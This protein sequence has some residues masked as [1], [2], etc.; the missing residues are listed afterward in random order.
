MAP[1]LNAPCTGGQECKTSY[2]SCV[3]FDNA[4]ER[5]ANQLIMERQLM[6]RKIGYTGLAVA[7]LGFFL[8]LRGSSVEAGGCLNFETTILIVVGL[9]T[10][11]A[12]AIMFIVVHSKYPTYSAKGYKI[13]MIPFLEYEP[14]G[15]VTNKK[16]DQQE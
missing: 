4:T 12:M 10:A 7:A 15:A 3:S 11:V 5:C 1:G 13:G 16:T 8:W 2:E 14:T 6:F 9:V